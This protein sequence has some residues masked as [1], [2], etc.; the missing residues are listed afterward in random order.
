CRPLRGLWLL[1]DR[2]SPGLRP[3]LL[4]CRPLRALDQLLVHP[5][6]AFRRAISFATSHGCI[7]A[8]EFHF[9]CAPLSVSL[10][11]GG[12]IRQRVL[13]TQLFHNSRECVTQSLPARSGY[14]RAARF[15]SKVF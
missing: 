15:S 6:S 3:V 12:S 2:V 9:D 13:M 1:C 7:S 4:C 14:V 11:V 8:I 10:A 5:K